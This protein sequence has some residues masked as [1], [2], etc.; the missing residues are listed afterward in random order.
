MA[1]N[2]QICFGNLGCQC[3][4]HRSAFGG[5]SQSLI[6]RLD[7]YITGFA[8]VPLLVSIAD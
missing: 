4:V 5:D 6:R 1:I 3:F 2:I 8:S 7:S